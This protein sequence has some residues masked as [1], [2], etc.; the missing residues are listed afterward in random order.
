MPDRRLNILVISPTRD[1]F[2]SAGEERLRRTLPEHDF[3]FAYGPSG[4]APHIAQAE[5]ILCVALSDEYARQAVRLKWI[6]ALGTGVDSIVGLPSLPPDVVITNMRGIHGAPVSEAALTMMFSLS[7]DI[8]RCIRNQAERRWEGF[9]P[10]LLE[11]K[12]V[13]ILGTGVIGEALARKCRGLGMT[14]VGF[15]ATPRELAGFDRMRHRSELIQAAG[16]LDY[17]VLLTPLTPATER[18]I[19][20]GVLKAMKPTSYLIN[21]GRGGLVDEPALV[22]ALQEGWIAGAGLDC[23]AREPL[24]AES[25]LWPLKNVV[26][27]PH[28]AGRHD[29]Y[30][31]EALEIF[32]K[33]LRHYLAGD[34]AHMVNIVAQQ[35]AAG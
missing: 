20:A 30:M 26:I 17:L 3:V 27:T 11:G 2:W 6:Q 25:P 13:G 4:A 31:D 5:V 19:H 35:Q 14:V 16:E 7:R 29:G 10:V 8:G 33:N 12:T 24:P 23:F 32:E 34:R 21:V 1:P 28:M 15:T 22:T 18:I 9:N